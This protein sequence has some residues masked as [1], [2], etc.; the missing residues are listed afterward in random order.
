[1]TFHWYC[2]SILSL[3]SMCVCVCVCVSVRVVRVCL[4]QG[5]VYLKMGSLESA[6]GA[7]NALHGGWY[8][9]MIN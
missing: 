4:M 7:Y 9:G 5:C 2:V 8:K 1:M 6:M 3:P